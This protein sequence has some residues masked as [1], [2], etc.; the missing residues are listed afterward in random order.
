M[1][2]LTTSAY[3]VRFERKNIDFRAGQYVTVG[4]KDDA[5][6][7]EYSIYSG[8][9]EDFIDIL[10]REVP[11]GDLSLQLKH[12]RTGQMLDVKGPA[13]SMTLQDKDIKR[14]HFAFIATGT[15]I[16]PFHSIV[17]SHT[18]IDYTIIH[19]VRF[20]EECYGKDDYDAR[21]YV[22]CTSGE[23][24]GNFAGRVTA[25]ISGISFTENTLY[26]LCGN[27]SMIYDVYALLR[28]RNTPLEK[29]RTEV[30]F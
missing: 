1:E 5:E 8:E 27:S 22:L 6:Q 14:M 17:K 9:N 23:D 11:D 13:G 19:G 7:R 12:C 4:L 16:A 25:Y 28:N 26:Y 29:I 18:A 30:F 20:A 24:N 10:V 2:L 15:G 3:I 21:R